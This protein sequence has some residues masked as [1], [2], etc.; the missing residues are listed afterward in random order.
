MNSRKLDVEFSKLRESCSGCLMEIP[1]LNAPRRLTGWSDA[2]LAEKRSK[3]RFPLEVF[4]NTSLPL[5]LTRFYHFYFRGVRKS[6][7]DNIAAIVFDAVAI[8]RTSQGMIWRAESSSL[9]TFYVANTSKDTKLTITEPGALIRPKR[10]IPL[11]A[12]QSDAAKTRYLKHAT[13]YTDQNVT[14]F[15]TI[16]T[17]RIRTFDA[18]K[19]LTP[20]FSQFL[21]TT[22]FLAL[23]LLRAATNN[24]TQ[25]TNAFLKKQYRAN[26]ATL[27]GWSTDWAF[28]PPCADCIRVCVIALGK[29]IKTTS[30][31]FVMLVHEY[32]LS[33]SKTYENTAVSDYLSAAVLT[34]TAMNG[35]GILQLMDHACTATGRRW[36][37]LHRLSCDDKVTYEDW[38]K[39]KEFYETYVLANPIQ[40]GYNWARII[41]DG[42][43]TGY[44]PKDM[45][46]LAGIF[47]GIIE[48]KE[49][50][51]IWEAG[52]ARDQKNFLSNMRIFGNGLYDKC[53][54]E[55]A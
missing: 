5:I 30:D 16:V 23:T 50:P 53:R 32:V 14:E 26:L 27:A 25:L 54:K 43:L 7:H 49:G 10:P 4:D 37:E 42:Y 47:A 40:F 33:K 8:A 9:K 35:L 19:A 17:D 41:D 13:Q 28:V 24:E 1:K 3:L 22:S 18:T 46:P 36:T 38:K 39:I 15:L 21:Q 51:G 29:S 12:I 48:K 20:E 34:H 44:S 55:D 31:M 2:M 45:L 6:D 52:W 11:T